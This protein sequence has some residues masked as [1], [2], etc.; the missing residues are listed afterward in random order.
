MYGI[1]S[2]IVLFLTICFFGCKKHFEEGPILSLKSKNKRLRGVWQMQHYFIDNYDSID[3]FNDFFK[4]KCT[5][6]IYPQTESGERFPG[7]IIIQWGN[8]KD[9]SQRSIRNIKSF[10]G[11]FFYGEINEWAGGGTTY[12][13]KNNFGSYAFSALI[14]HASFD[15]RYLND[16]KII[17]ELVSQKGNKQRMEFN[18]TSN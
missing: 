6:N 16:D 4:G 12:P 15:I 14:Q 9:T 17:L 1:K 13:K 10:Y 11:R 8:D 3:F 2:I 5:F 7:T 18:K